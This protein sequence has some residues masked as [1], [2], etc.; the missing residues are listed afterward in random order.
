MS[1]PSMRNTTKG[2][3]M[4]ARTSSTAV[5]AQCKHLLVPTGAQRHWYYWLCTARKWEP[6]YNPVTGQN[7]KY[8]PYH[9]AKDINSGDCPAYEPG[10]NELKPKATQ[11]GEIL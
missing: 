1:E 6:A 8:P 10:P 2:D 9:Y 3:D 11:D 7:N 4:Y 5:C